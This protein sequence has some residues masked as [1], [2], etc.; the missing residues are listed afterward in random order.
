MAPLTDFRLTGRTK[1]RRGRVLLELP[2]SRPPT[3]G[4]LSSNNAEPVLEPAVR[5]LP[6]T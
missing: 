6:S 3:S 5:L 2:L 1:A 4:W